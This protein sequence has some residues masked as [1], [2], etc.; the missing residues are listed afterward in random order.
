[1]MIFAP[2]A[3]ASWRSFCVM[4]VESIAASSMTSSCAQALDRRR[5]VAESSEER[6]R[7]LSSVERLLGERG[8]GLFDLDGVHRVILRSL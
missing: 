5:L 2:L 1:M 3:C 7:K 6:E 4:R 8:Y